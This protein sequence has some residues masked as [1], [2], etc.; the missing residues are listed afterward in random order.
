[1]Y[2]RQISWSFDGR[3]LGLIRDQRLLFY[4]LATN[5]IQ[6]V[7]KDGFTPHD[8]AFNPATLQVG[9]VG[10]STNK[11]KIYLEDLQTGE[12]LSAEYPGL[13]E[14]PLEV[15][16][17]PTGDL[18]A[19]VDNNG[20]VIIWDAVVLALVAELPSPHQSSTSVIFT[21]DGQSVIATSGFGYPV[22]RWD[23]TN[24]RTQPA[25]AQE[26]DLG[27]TPYISK[28][29]FSPDGSELA[30]N[31]RSFIERNSVFEIASFSQSPTKVARTTTIKSIST[32]TNFNSLDYSPDGT[33]IVNGGEDGRI[34]L[35]AAKTGA[36]LRILEVSRSEIL[37]ETQFNP[38]GT[39]LASVSS[40]NII[41]F[42]A[43]L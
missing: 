36:S 27:M 19:T 20:R 33:L 22:L 43:I 40:D 11:T 41:R 3:I 18:I 32:N 5:T 29:S 2:K 38:L 25:I 4:D 23:V 31:V 37:L 24:I 16:F 39:L 17:N 13:Y 21:P 30:F 42:W 12:Q 28:I 7:I 9:Y 6:T 8:I 35:R 14:S 1:V 34:Y 26:L 15:M 10:S